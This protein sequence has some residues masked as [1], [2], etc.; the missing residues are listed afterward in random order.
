[1]LAFVASEEKAVNGEQ[2]RIT[3][4]HLASPTAKLQLRVWDMTEA[5]L[6]H[7]DQLRDQVVQVSRIRLT[8]FGDSKIGEILDSQQGTR[9]Q[10]YADAALEQYWREYVRS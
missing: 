9:F 1:M 5:L 4:V 7:I 10:P 6:A 8:T 3:P 2:R